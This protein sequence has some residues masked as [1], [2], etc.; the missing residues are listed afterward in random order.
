MVNSGSSHQAF[1]AIY[2]LDQVLGRARHYLD[3]VA[4]LTVLQRGSLY[5]RWVAAIVNLHECTILGLK[6]IICGGVDLKWN[7]RSASKRCR[8]DLTLRGTH[9]EK[10]GSHM[11]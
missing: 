3:L 10:I 1:P 5:Y 7:L 11:W 2:Y 8:V 4:T 9:L 6:M